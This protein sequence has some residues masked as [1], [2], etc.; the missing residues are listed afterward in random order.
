MALVTWRTGAGLLSIYRSGETSTILGIPTWYTYAA[1]LPGLFW[2]ALAALYCAAEKW[3][4]G[5]R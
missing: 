3:R 5:A 4:E 2:C 1:M